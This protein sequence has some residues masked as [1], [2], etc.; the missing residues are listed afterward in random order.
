MAGTTLDHVLLLGGIIVWARLVTYYLHRNPYLALSPPPSSDCVKVRFEH[1]LAVVF[2]YTVLMVAASALLRPPQPPQPATH[3][4]LARQAILDLLAKT[5]ALI[6][7]AVFVLR[8]N[9]IKDIFT[10]SRADLLHH[11]LILR[12]PVW[13]R[14]ILFAAAVYLAIYVLIYLLINLGLFIVV[15]LLKQPM[16][17]AHPALELLASPGLTAPV[18]IIVILSATLISPIAEELFFRG[19]LQNFLLKTFRRPGLAIVLTSL[20]FMSV[21]PP[22]YHQ[23]P[24]WF[25]LGATF[26]WIYYR[27]RTLWAAIVIHII[28]NSVSLIMFYLPKP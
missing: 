24:A 14:T 16:P 12:L 13:A 18:R 7:M 19:L 4:L 17:A 15:H 5:A 27:Y 22:L 10:L 26:G 21:H 9:L 11:R 1:L 3:D 8:Y 6:L 2:V 23:Y 20:A 28:F 25:V